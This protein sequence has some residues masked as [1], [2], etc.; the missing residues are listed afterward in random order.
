MKHLI[1]LLA[2]AF[3]LVSFSC[4][5]AL[6]FEEQLDLDKELIADYVAANNLSGQSTSNGIFYG[7]TEPG[8]TTTF[9]TLTSTVEVVYTGKLLDGT[10]FD[11]S[12]GFPVSFQLF[13]TIQG[14][15]Q[16]VPFFSEGAKGY[17][18]IPSNLAYGL[19]GSGIIP[20]NAVLYFDIEL[21]DVR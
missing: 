1:R 17:L 19:R 10:V 6:T 7:F 15:Q 4:D 16:G 18:L 3:V 8:D 11:S 5:N 9:P 2:F 20:P 21:L 14:W 13:Q 12:E